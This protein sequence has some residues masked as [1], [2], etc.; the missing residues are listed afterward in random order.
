MIDFKDGDTTVR[1]MT[2]RHWFT[3]NEV[4]TILVT[5]YNGGEGITKTEYNNIKKYNITDDFLILE[6]SKMDVLHYI[7]KDQVLEFKVNW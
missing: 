3:E 4:C 7:Q 1:T 6:D 2:T 5:K